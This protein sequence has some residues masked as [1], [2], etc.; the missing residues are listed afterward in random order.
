MTFIRWIETKITD[1]R[2]GIYIYV[3]KEIKLY[4]DIKRLIV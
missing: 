2:R 3:H 4:K 1:M